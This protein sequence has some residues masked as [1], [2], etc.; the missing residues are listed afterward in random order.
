MWSGPYD[1]SGDLVSQPHAPRREG[2]EG[3]NSP[4]SCTSL[5]S[6]SVVAQQEAGGRGGLLL[7]SLLDIG[8]TA[9]SWRGDR[10]VQVNVTQQRI[11]NLIQN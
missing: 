1:S 3:P 6:I 11:N 8:K 10:E 7:V 5:L 4:T 9:E 2:A